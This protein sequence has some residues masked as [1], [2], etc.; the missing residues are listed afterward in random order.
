[1]QTLSEA[2]ILELIAQRKPL[3]ARVRGGSLRIRIDQ[4]LPLVVTVPHAGTRLSAEAARRLALDET[5][6]Q[7]LEERG[8]DR[9]AELL[10]ISIIVD[11]SRL[12]C[13]LAQPLSHAIP[14]THDAAPLWQRPPT[15]RMQA[16]AETAYRRYYRILDALI[17]ALEA[18]CGSCLLVDLHSHSLGTAAAG[19]FHIRADSDLRDGKLTLIESLQQRLSELTLPNLASSVSR[20]PEPGEGTWLDD[21]IE[22]RHPRTRVLGLIVAP[23]YR[24]RR[25]DTLYPVLVDT[26]S[27]ALHQVLLDTAAEFAARASGRPVHRHDLLPDTLPTEVLQ[28][29]RALKRLAQGLETLLYINP[30]NLATEQRR[31][32]RSDGRY[33]PEFRYRPLKIDPFAHREQ[34]YRLPVD[35]IRDPALRQLYREVIDALAQRID[36]LVSIGSD[37]F[38]YNSL[39]YY[40]E[41]TDTDLANARFLLHAA[42]REQ[43]QAP[44]DNDAC[45]MLNFF[46]DCARNWGLE[47]KTELSDRILSAAMVSGGRRA[48]MVRRDART[49]DSE[50]HALAHHELGVHMTTS[51]NARRQPLQLFTLGLPGN[52]HAQEGLAIL[53]EYL[54][55]HLTLARLKTLAL[56][57]IA[58]HQM[59]HHNDLRRTWRTLTEDYGCNALDAFRI[60]A[61]VHRGGGFTKDYLYLSGFC[62]ALQLYRSRDIGALL[63]GKTGFSYLSLLDDLIDRKLLLPPRHL[64]PALESPVPSHPEIDYLV[65]SI[66]AE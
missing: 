14:L 12:T 54:G 57:V 22:R 19:L 63:I 6:R 65:R 2:R 64:P 62:Q 31:F 9:L 51:L 45:T 18:S 29:D 17:D 56:R 58:V 39:R 48:L 42:E 49:T 28:L 61:R 23:L 4:Y 60:S 34:L 32:L 46:R 41:P 1:M 30:I 24:D 21:D 8:C 43:E 35:G 26:L 59:L 52:T 55:G 11:D 27:A 5:Q 13:D 38:L 36:L 7:Q 37:R 15:Q 50:M 33:R 66:R 20:G 44:R 53:S 3:H 25:G 40:G 16:R 10:P 47:C